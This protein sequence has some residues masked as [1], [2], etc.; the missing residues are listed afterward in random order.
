M[1]RTVAEDTYTDPQIH[2]NTD[3]GWVYGKVP[4]HAPPI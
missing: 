3:D 1:P 4:P 2:S